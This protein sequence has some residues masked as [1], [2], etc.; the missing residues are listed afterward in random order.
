MSAKGTVLHIS[1]V[2]TIMCGDN[3]NL[4]I[5]PILIADYIAMK[6]AFL[7][8]T[9]YLLQTNEETPPRYIQTVYNR[10]QN[11]TREYSS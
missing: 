1:A 3:S 5:F 9:G 8:C 11:A 2:L 10:M 7:I 6:S 4:N